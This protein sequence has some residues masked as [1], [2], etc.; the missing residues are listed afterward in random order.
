MDV[1]IIAPPFYDCFPKITVGVID[2]SDNWLNGQPCQACDVLISTRWV[3]ARNS[4]VIR[5]SFSACTC[6]T[7]G[8]DVGW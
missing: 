8:G 1:A 6:S 3:L 7:R 4:M 2:A 5:W